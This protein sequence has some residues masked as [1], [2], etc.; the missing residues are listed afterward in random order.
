[1]TTAFAPAG[2]W[3]MSMF[4]RL[5]VGI[6]VLDTSI[7]VDT[8]LMYRDEASQLGAIGGLN[9]SIAT[10]CLVVLY[11][12]WLM[13]AGIAAGYARYQRLY[14]NLPLTAYL[15]IA[16][17]SAV[18]ANDK[19]LSLNSLVLLAQSYLLFTYIANWAAT[20]EDVVYIVGLFAAALAIQGV[21]MIGLRVI[22]HSVSLGPIAATIGDDMRT[23]GTIGSPVTGGSFLALMYRADVVAPGDPRAAELQTARDDGALSRRHRAVAHADARF[24]DRSRILCVRVFCVGVAARLGIV[25]VADVMPVRGHRIRGYFP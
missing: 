24:M 17:L 7:Q 3:N 22:G 1:M 23:A 11:A 12:M 13:E 10:L 2:H 19:L 9:L 5:L 15:G 14:I 25:E 4:Q 8:Y 6:A 20:R 18:A 16:A 21:V